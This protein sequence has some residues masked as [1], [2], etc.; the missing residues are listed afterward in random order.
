M[1]SR[2]SADCVV[3]SYSSSIRAAAAPGPAL[4]CPSAAAARLSRAV[5][6]H[7]TIML[8]FLTHKLRTHSLNEDNVS[9]KVGVAPRPRRSRG[10]QKMAACRGTKS[11]PASASSG[12]EPQC[13][14]C[15]PR[16]CR[17]PCLVLQVE[18]RDSGTESDDEAER[19]RDNCADVIMKWN[20][21]TDIRACDAGC[22][23]AAPRVPEPDLLYDHHSSEEELEV[24]NG[25]PRA[26]AG[27]E[28]SR[29]RGAS[30]PPPAAP[31]KRKWPARADDDDDDAKVE[32]PVRFRT[33]PPLEALKPRRSG[34]GGECACPAGTPAGAAGGAG[35]GSPRRRR[36]APPPP[37]R[38]RPALDFDK[39]Q[40][41]KVGGAGVRSWRGVGGA[42]GE[43]S[44]FCW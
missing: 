32:T 7:D 43:L 16:P 3:R 19:D 41:L 44:V 24:I 20:D 15:S 37:R 25:L 29:R 38:H 26:G 2:T 17:S 31:E 6:T 5:P 1:R 11:R 18:E 40:Q 14:E 34:A 36:Q 21:V 8:K 33:S 9:E 10:D 4:P 23:C 22:G 42:G 30:S 13:R 28:A 27:A 35:G 12:R 39:M